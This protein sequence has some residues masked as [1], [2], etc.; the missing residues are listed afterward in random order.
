[1]LFETHAFVK[2]SNT[3]TDE[4][5]S[6]YASGRTGLCLELLSKGP[7]INYTTRDGWGSQSSSK[8]E[9]DAGSK[10]TENDQKVT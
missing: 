10:Y 6:A 7:S 5:T 2:S 3:P 1:M 8:T 9:R 4:L